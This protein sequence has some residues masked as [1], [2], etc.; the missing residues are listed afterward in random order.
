MTKMLLKSIFSVCNVGNLCPTDVVQEFSLMFYQSLPT[1]CCKKSRS[2]E[3][4]EDI[5]CKL[6][7]SEQESVNHVM[8]HCGDLVNSLFTKRNDNALKCF[9]WLMLKQF[10]LVKKMSCSRN[11]FDFWWDIPEYTESKRPPRR[12]GKLRCVL[13]TSS[14]LILE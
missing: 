8:S 13:D 7:N 5:W 3:Q 11:D 6:C 14:K 2:T 10:G 12:D 4:I 9:V 1:R